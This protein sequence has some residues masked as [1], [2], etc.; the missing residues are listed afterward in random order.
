M[1]MSGIYVRFTSEQ[2]AYTETIGFIAPTFKWEVALVW[3]TGE[4]ERKGRKRNEGKGKME[5]KKK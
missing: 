4:G 2:F 1:V 5:E 3:R